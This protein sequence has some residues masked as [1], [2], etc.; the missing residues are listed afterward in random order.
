MEADDNFLRSF[1]LFN[2]G[3]EF[4]SWIVKKH[5]CVMSSSSSF[6]SQMPRTL[7]IAA[8]RP[9]ASSGS[10]IT[11]AKWPDGRTEDCLRP[12]KEAELEIIE[13]RRDE[14]LDLLFN[15]SLVM[16]SASSHSTVPILDPGK[17]LDPPLKGPPLLL[18][19]TVLFTA[20]FGSRMPE[21]ELPGTPVKLA[22]LKLCE[23]ASDPSLLIEPGKVLDPVPNPD[24]R[25]DAPANEDGRG[26]DWG[27]VF[28]P[29]VSVG[30]VLERSPPRILFRDISARLRDASSSV[31]SVSTTLTSTAPFWAM[32]PS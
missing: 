31:W 5:F 27:L 30:M 16:L 2:I 17:D 15:Q 14:G 20:Q 11:R 7:N 8:F 9:P 10:D 4:S 25:G 29:R 6:A 18:S 1:V 12:A 32:L 22:P 23:I 21:F 26:D 13:T 19:L 3:R 28:S 24:S